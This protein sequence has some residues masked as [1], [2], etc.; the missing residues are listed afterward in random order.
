VVLARKQAN[1]MAGISVTMSHNAIQS[2]IAHDSR[3]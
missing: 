3:T 2:L 1:L